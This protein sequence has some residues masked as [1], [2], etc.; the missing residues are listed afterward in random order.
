[1]LYSGKLQPFLSCRAHICCLLLPA[2]LS[3]EALAVF[4]GWGGSWSTPGQETSP[5]SPSPEAQRYHPAFQTLL[6]G[7]MP[8]DLLK[9]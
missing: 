5:S 8:L 7:S 4:V 3:V 9:I 1:M 6:D 2:V